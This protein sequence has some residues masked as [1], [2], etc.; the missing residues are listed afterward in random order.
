[1][2]VLFAAFR[3]DVRAG[4]S[5]RVAE[6]LASSLRQVGVETRVAF[7]YGG[8]GPVGRARQVPCDYLGLSGSRDLTHWPRFRALV[9]SIRPEIVHF[10]DPSIWMHAMA[11]GGSFR[12]VL[13]VHGAVFAETATLR[14]QLAWRFTSS[15]VDLCVC[16]THGVRRSLIEQ[17]LVPANRTAVVY[18]GVDTGWFDGRPSRAAARRTLGLPADV[19]MIGMVC[20][21]VE[22]RACD[23]FLRVLARLGPSW[24]G[25]LAGDGPARP[26]LER[27]AS[28]LGLLDRVWFAGALPDVRPAYAAL[29]VYAFLALY[30]SFGLATA[31]AMACRV[32]VVGLAGRGE[33]REPDNPLVTAETAVLFDR[34]SRHVP[35]D[36][37][38]PALLDRLAARVIE[39]ADHEEERARVAGRAYAHVAR[40][41]SV[42]VQRDAMLEVYRSLLGR[43]VE[44]SS[45]AVASVRG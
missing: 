4:G 5:L 36:A 21:L 1:V 33:Y 23:D 9:R 22:N 12:K 40:R 39:L 11:F 13:H 14:D 15:Q 30:D 41:F 44:P 17:G 16:I 27:L 32:P 6:S 19:P 2:K 43:P 35:S 7:G 18:N 8:E 31:E 3:D 29:D 34:V 20:R 42:A 25:L 28:D 38:D 37:E 26:A 10:I 45:P 24:H